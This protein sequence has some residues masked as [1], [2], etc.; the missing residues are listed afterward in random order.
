MDAG[1]VIVGRLASLTSAQSRVYPLALPQEPTFP[2][3]VY[4]QVSAVRTHAMGQDAAIVRCRV[5][6]DMRGNTYAEA[7]ALAGEVLARL[8]RFKG[9]V[10]AYTVHDILFDNESL[11]YESESNTRRV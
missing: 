7:R 3:V 9:V 8:N 4:Q 6:L 2:A 10:G 11:T 1:L 5:Q